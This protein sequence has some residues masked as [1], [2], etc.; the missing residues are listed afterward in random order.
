M[1]RLPIHF[2]KKITNAN[3][4]VHRVFSEYMHWEWV[5]GLAVRAAL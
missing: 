5:S 3:N 1:Q 2:R 4:P